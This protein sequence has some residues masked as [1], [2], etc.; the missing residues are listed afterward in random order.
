MCHVLFMSV[1][2]TWTLF[3]WSFVF[4]CFFFHFPVILLILL[5][6]WGD[7][8]ENEFVLVTLDYR[9]LNGEKALT[10]FNLNARHP[11]HGAS[12]S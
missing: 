2:L 5:V 6:C 9:L 3:I 10:M 4:V 12:S 11:E 1:V 7:Y 8:N